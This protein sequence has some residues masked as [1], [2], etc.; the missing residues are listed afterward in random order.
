MNPAPSELLRI[1]AALHP[2]QTAP[3]GPGWNLAELGGLLPDIELQQAAVLLGLVPRAAGIQ[4]LLTRRTNA[5]RHHAG[6]V[7]FPGGRIEPGD[8]DP[9]VAAIREAGEEIGLAPAQI[10]PLGWLD[11]LLTITGF[12]VLP[13]VAAIAPDYL[14]RP[15]PREVDAVFEVPL[16]FLLAP[17]HLAWIQITYA[18]RPRPVLEFVDRGIPEQRIW[19]ATASILFNLRERLGASTRLEPGPDSIRR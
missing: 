8:A 18:G 3:A 4:V 1:R 10:Q 19:G 5:L 7:S 11:P 12:R 14:A 13:L 2:L 15:D 6:Q 17:E 16:D 9:A